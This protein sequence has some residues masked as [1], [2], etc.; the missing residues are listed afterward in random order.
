M[1]EIRVGQPKSGKTESIKKELKFENKKLLIFDF[2]N[3][4]KKEN[5]KFFNFEE[6]HPLIDALGEEE[7]KVINAGYLKTSKCLYDKAMEIL[8]EEKIERRTGIIQD[9]LER[10]NA[11]WKNYEVEYYR[12]LSP[13]IPCKI[14]S[15]S[16]SLDIIVE[17]LKENDTVII[18]SK[19]IYSD[20]LRTLTYLLLYK[21][22]LNEDLE[23]K[24]I[25]DEISSL[26]FKGNLKMLFEVVESEKIDV[27][28]SCNRATTIPKIMK[29][30]VHSWKLFKN[31]DKKE[32]QTLSEIFELK[33]KGKL[34]SLSVGEF[35]TIDQGGKVVN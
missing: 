15:K 5:A 31:T 6:F 13:R 7:I 9:T 1:F 28:M 27:V 4:Y 17:A 33:T 10:L 8:E 26:F 3:V 16:K 35:V 34:N 18:N 25:A 22:S 14:N 32:I 12:E 23:V 24:V 30:K 11:S 20:L 29:E 2:N 21:I 19:S